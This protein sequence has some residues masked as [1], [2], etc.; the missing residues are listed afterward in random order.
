MG[1]FERRFNLSY[2]KPN[3]TSLE[4]LDAKPR[5][6]TDS[7]PAMSGDDS[8]VSKLSQRTMGIGYYGNNRRENKEHAVDVDLK[9]PTMEEATDDGNSAQTRDCA[10]SYVNYGCR[11]STEELMGSEEKLASNQESQSLCASIDS[12]KKEARSLES[13]SCSWENLYESNINYKAEPLA[14][15]IN[16]SCS[17]SYPL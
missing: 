7:K 1:E 6:S 11:S 12:E 10:S 5:R 8:E 3:A 2:C 14:G 4:V 16:V 9:S 17:K 15:L 13:I